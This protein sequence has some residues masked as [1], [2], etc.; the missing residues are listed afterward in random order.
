MLFLILTLFWNLL[1]FL[2]CAIFCFVPLHIQIIVY[3]ERLNLNVCYY[4]LC[5]FIT[6]GVGW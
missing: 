3:T 2:H 6:A 5:I 1:A 4:G